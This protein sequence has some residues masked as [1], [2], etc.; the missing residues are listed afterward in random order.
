MLWTKRLEDTSAEEFKKLYI[1]L[2]EQL[3]PM[4]DSTLVS[5]YRAFNN[6]YWPA[7]L[8]EQPVFWDKIPNYENAH[9]GK[10]LTK[11]D[12]IRPYAFVITEMVPDIN[13]RIL[14]LF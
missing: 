5:I 8:G 3:E 4:S 9:T 13:Q 11:V 2:V 6:W 14:L 7:Q 1:S 12:I 10:C